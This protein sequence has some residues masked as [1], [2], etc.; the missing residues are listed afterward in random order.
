MYMFVHINE[1][2]KREKPEKGLKKLWLPRLMTQKTLT[3]R[4]NNS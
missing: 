4:E 3:G 1:N 2:K